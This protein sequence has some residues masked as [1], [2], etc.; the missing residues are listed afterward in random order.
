MQTHSDGFR[1]FALSR[2]GG[3]TWDNFEQNRSL[4]CPKCQAS[5]TG[6]TRSESGDVL[7]FSNPSPPDRPGPDKGDRVNMVVRLSSDGGQTWASHRTLHAGPAAYSCLAVLPDG[8]AACLYEAG[9]DSPYEHLIF[10][11]FPLD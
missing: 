2:D 4:P 9:E 8:D 11:R 1:G 6:F 5:L 10:E 7:L 3:A